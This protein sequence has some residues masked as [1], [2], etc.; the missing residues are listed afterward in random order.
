MERLRWIRELGLDPQVTSRVHQNR[1][2]QLA[3]EG[4][5]MTAQRL[6]EFDVARRD[7]TLVAF[8]LATAEDLVDQALDMHDKLL[9]QQFKKGERKQ[10]GQ[11]KKSRKAINEKVRLYARVGKALITAKEATQDAY[12]AIESVLPWER[13]VGTVQEAEQ[14]STTTTEVDTVEI[15]VSRYPQ[16]RKYTKELLATFEFQATKANEPLLKALAL[17]NSLNEA[18]RRNVPKLAPTAFVTGT[19]FRYLGLY[20]SG[21]WHGTLAGLPLCSAY[22]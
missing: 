5:R 13:F 4:A 20:R 18:G 17:L 8:L 2:Q 10:E 22:S 7:A 14:L 16:L 21:F 12:V 15:L 6:G 11:I 3:R 9:G 19:L 1:L